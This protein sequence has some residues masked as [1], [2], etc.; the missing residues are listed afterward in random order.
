MILSI[1]T[2]R[3]NLDA[4][5]IYPGHSVFPD[6]LPRVDDPYCILHTLKMSVV[7]F[8]LKFLPELLRLLSTSRAQMTSTLVHP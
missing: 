3:Q 2:F 5:I 1:P 6:F 8:N 7:I 4:L